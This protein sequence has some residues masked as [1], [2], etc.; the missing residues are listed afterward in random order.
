MEFFRIKTNIDFIGK[1]IYALAFSSIL[2]LI[3]II[4]LIIHNGPRYGV[5]FSGGISVRAKFSQPVTAA[6]IKSGI[7]TLNLTNCTVQEF[8]EK[9]QNEFQIQSGKEN[10]DIENIQASLSQVLS[11]KFGKGG[12]EIR[13]VETVGP[14]VGK[15]LRKKGLWAV[16]ISWVMMLIYV[17]F[18]FKH[19][20]FGLGGIVALAHDVMITLGAFSIT[21]R[22]I[23]LTI[24]A[25]LLTII[26]FSINDTIVIYDRVRENRRKAPN[27]LLP[28]IINQSINETLSRTIITTGTVLLG[29][30]ALLLFGG[31]VIHDFAFAMLVG[32]ISGT[33]STLYIASPVVILWEDKFKG[34]KKRRY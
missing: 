34:K 12:F 24:V 6:E 33:Y 32:C 25:A 7:Q 30:V 21:N 1:K 18:R 17:A 23:D 20:S 27:A 2:I 15:D 22:E 29:V 13:K 26:G 19:F 28:E 4:S 9:G 3:T 5:D 10:L 16:V 8:I 14:K 31:G 11:K